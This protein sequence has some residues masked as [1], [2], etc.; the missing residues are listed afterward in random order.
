MHTLRRGHVVARIVETAVLNFDDV[1][2]SPNAPYWV[3]G[4]ERGIRSWSP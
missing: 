3:G 2:D 4:P 1:V